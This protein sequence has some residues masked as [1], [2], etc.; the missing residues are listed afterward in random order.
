MT[1]FLDQ[2]LEMIRQ[3]QFDRDTVSQQILQQE[4]TMSTA[5][6]DM[7]QQSDYNRSTMLEQIAQSEA[8]QKSAVGALIAKN[9]A[10]SWAIMEQIKILELEL[11]KVTKQE[12]ERKKLQMDEQLNE[13][14]NRRIEIMF[15]L[16]DLMEQ[17]QQRKS[18]LMSTLEKME[19]NRD[20]DT[21]HY[22][23]LQY[24]RV[25]DHMAPEQWLQVLTIDP[26][27][28]H[29]FLLY[30]VIHC[31]PFL[32]K[33]WRD[34]QTNITSVTDDQL[35]EAGIK[36]D[37]DRYNILR[38]IEDYAN[39]M[40]ASAPETQEISSNDDD[41]NDDEKSEARISIGSE[42]VV[43]LD[44]AVQMLFIPCGHMCCCFTCQISL[45]ECPMCRAPIESR[46]KVI[47][48]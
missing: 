18:E 42:C 3:Y 9:D 38:A 45:I 46:I 15:V 35:K 36:N 47:H 43:C 34:I 21:D 39:E 26:R 6:A 31:L 2:E 27:L 44:L 30:G 41:D 20:G 4:A 17:Q 1:S 13:L 14:A 12:I 24:Q 8:L 29:L 40:G 48:S 19:A 16:M 33:V 37:A 32:Y 10:R 23:L 5:L 7:I 11:G 25:L 22:W 28:G